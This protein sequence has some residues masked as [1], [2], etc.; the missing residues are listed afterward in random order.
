MSVYCLDLQKDSLFPPN[1][2]NSGTI[3]MFS[4]LKVN[5]IFKN[6][7]LYFALD[8]VWNCMQGW[9]SAICLVKFSC[10][11]VRLCCICRGFHP[12]TWRAT[13]DMPLRRHEL[14]RDDTIGASEVACYDVLLDY[15]SELWAAPVFFLAKLFK[16]YWVLRDMHR[17]L[18]ALS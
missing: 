14:K 7:S 6:N 18:G 12:N 11:S 5:R 3:F 16:D 8:G 10:L 15:S 9:F 2:F 13:A 17:Y 1:L 4:A